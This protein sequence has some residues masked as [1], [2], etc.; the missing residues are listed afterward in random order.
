[1]GW[2][3]VCDYIGADVHPD[4]LRKA[5]ATT[6]YGG[7]SVA[8]YLMDKTAN[9]LTEDMIA[10]LEKKKVEEYKERVR[11]QDA[12]R[13]YNKELRAEAR[14]ESLREILQEAMGS[15]QT[16]YTGANTEEQKLECDIAMYLAYKWVYGRQMHALL[17][18]E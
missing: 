3:E 2:D 5:F 16:F 13:E 18:G 15:D 6:E 9:E 7:Y 1:M 8:K 12:R 11:L 14:Y 4:S 17:H 10:S